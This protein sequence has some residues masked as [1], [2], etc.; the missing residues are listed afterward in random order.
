MEVDSDEYTDDYIADLDLVDDFLFKY[1][2]QIHDLYDDL[3]SRFGIYSPFFLCNMELYHL[4][5]FFADIALGF[6]EHRDVKNKNILSI[7]DNFYKNE[8]DIS[9][10]IV[11]HFS[12]RFLKLNFT[13]DNWLK[14]CYNLTDKYELIH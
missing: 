6:A 13:Y 9:Y 14:F 8:L 2:D 4:T 1:S 12:K 10:S 5:H 3:K 7:F 11:S